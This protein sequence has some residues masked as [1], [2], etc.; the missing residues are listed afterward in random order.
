MKT[1][2]VEYGIPP[3]RAVYFADYADDGQTDEDIEIL[4]A[5]TYQWPSGNP[6]RV[7]KK[8]T[9]SEKQDVVPL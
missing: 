5:E 1:I 6:K 4:F 7:I 9:R 8:I 2:Q 3:L